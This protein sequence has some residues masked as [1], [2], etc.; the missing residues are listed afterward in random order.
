[1]KLRVGTRGSDLALAQTQ[2]VVARLQQLHPRVEIEQVIITTHG[3]QHAGPLGGEHWPVGGFVGAIERELLAASD[4]PCHDAIL[5]PIL[6]S[7]KRRQRPELRH[8]GGTF[9]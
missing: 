2:W 3:D 6:S 8:G 4:L 5:A 9:S 1:M 7:H